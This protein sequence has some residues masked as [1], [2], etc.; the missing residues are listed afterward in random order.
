VRAGWIALCLASAAATAQPLPAQ[1]FAVDAEP[2]FK[3]V[4]PALQAYLAGQEAP[5]AR[6]GA[7]HF[8][9]VGYRSGDNRYAWV[10]WLEGQRLVYWEPAADDVESKETLTRSRRELNLRKDVVASTRELRGSSY[11]IDRPWLKRLLADCR[12]RGQAYDIRRP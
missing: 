9:V 2:G 12:R 1:T 11:R 7:Q 6:A 10:Y 8:C 3:P 5:A 4:Q